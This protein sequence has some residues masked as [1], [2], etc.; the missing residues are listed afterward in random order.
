MKP[1]LPSIVS[2]FSHLALGL[3]LARLAPRFGAIYAQRDPDP[4][5]LPALTRVVLALAPVGWIAIA[6]IL[7]ALAVGKDLHPR[8]RHLPNWPFRVAL[9]LLG[10]IAIA[11]LYLPLLTGL[12]APR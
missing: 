5:H 7:A 8:T 11:G 2:A 4:S 9:V 1:T 3:I 12:H 6:V 10:G